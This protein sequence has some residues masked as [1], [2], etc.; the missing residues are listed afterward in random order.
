[1]R[2]EM[3]VFMGRIMDIVRGLSVLLSDLAL[4]SLTALLIPV[5]TRQEIT[6]GY[7]VWIGCL[8]LQFVLSYGMMN[9]GISMNLYL[10]FQVVAVA[11]GAYFTYQSSACLE[12]LDMGSVMAAA[13]GEPRSAM[14]YLMLC[15]AAS[16]IHS[17]WMAWRLPSSNTVLRYVDCLIVALAFYL[18]AV[19]GTEMIQDATLVGLSLA[20]ILLDLLTV[21][22]LRTREECPFVIQGAGN[23]AR[24]MLLVLFVVCMLVT[25]G[26][27]GL[28]FGQV[29]SL[30][31]LLLVI[32]A[33]IWR[34]VYAVAG[35]VGMVLGYILFFVIALLPNAPPGART[36]AAEL[37]SQGTEKLEEYVGSAVPPWVVWLVL[38]VLAVAG[39]LVLLY[40]FRHIR[41][42][43][44]RLQRGRRKVVKKSHV[45]SALAALAAGA[46]ARIR[47]EIRYLRHRK[48]P[49][50]LLVLAERTGKHLHLGRG[51]GE[52]PGGYLRR[53]AE[54]QNRS[55]G[56][57]SPG[58]GRQKEQPVQEGPLLQEGRSLQ[59][60]EPPVQEHPP[61][62]KVLAEHLDRIYYR[63]EKIRLDTREYQEY[64]Y[65]SRGGENW[66]KTDVK[67]ACKTVF[68]QFSTSGGRPMLLVR[69]SRTRRCPP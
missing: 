6:I 61:S 30:V 33:G 13:P 7:Q 25:G 43:A 56:Q 36:R 3:G 35:A 45:L 51:P 29:H 9:T 69:R 41:L 46:M 54:Y 34:V 23:G 57:T 11:A 40:Q 21:N 20:A 67:L 26:I 22:Q 66:T 15:V 16:G 55:S 31:D 38:A 39:V 19:Y 42:K 12:T 63:N 27:V 32:L 65:S 52:S 68:V 47:F 28:A 64:G 48:T 8:A 53:L 18:Y 24:L 1:M 5:I 58:Q 10:V 50:G 2:K 4:A 59:G 37:V 62:L 17:G 60:E 14:V 44:V 49:Q